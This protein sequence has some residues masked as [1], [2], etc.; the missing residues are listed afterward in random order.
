MDDAKILDID[1]GKVI[2]ARRIVLNME[3]TRYGGVTVEDIILDS[4]IKTEFAEVL[5]E[6]ILK[7]KQRV[8]VDLRQDIHPDEEGVQIFDI[9]AVIVPLRK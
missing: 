6:T 3:L 1:K 5:V 7:M 9:R 2:C 8:V 4:G